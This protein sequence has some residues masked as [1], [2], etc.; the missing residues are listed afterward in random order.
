MRKSL[1]IFLLT[2]VVAVN[3]FAREAADTV[4]VT[5]FPT[6]GIAAPAAGVVTAYTLSRIYPHGAFSAV[7]PGKH[8]SRG[9][10][11][12]Q[13]APV[14]LPW[15]LKAAGVP[16]QSSWARMGVA[17]GS[18]IVINAALVWG[19]KHIID[20]QRPDGTDSRSFPSGHSAWAFAGATMIERELGVT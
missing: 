18:G 20:S 9:T 5:K 6:A 7:H 14:A 12:L 13:Y 3:A 16:T 17:Q 15:I 8:T 19:L 1:L 10:G 2:V 4:P 11:V